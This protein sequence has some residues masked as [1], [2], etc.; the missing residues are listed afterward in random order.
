M[1]SV[2]QKRNDLLRFVAAHGALLAVQGSV[3][4]TYRHYKGRR[5]GPFFRLSFRQAG[6]QRSLYIGRDRGLAS[7]IEGQL[8]TLQAPRSN[9]RQLERCLAECRRNLQAAKQEF[10][11]RLE[12]QGLRLQ[13]NEI[14]GWR[15]QRQ[16]AVAP[17]TPP[18]QMPR[19]VTRAP[20]THPTQRIADLGSER[21]ASRPWSVWRQLFCL[22][23]RPC[24][25]PRFAVGQG[26]NKNSSTPQ[27][28]QPQERA[29]AQPGPSAQDHTLNEGI[30]DHAVF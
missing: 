29:L 9:A 15:T 5:L 1:R 25:Q 26:C 6:K 16:L 12:A 20:S 17:P 13:G 27:E 11:C 8:Q 10:R 23:K 21:G 7:A 22:D 3:Q 18:G 19:P 30:P 2:N 28:C 24:C 14:R 4:E